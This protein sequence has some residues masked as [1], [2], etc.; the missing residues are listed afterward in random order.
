MACTCVRAGY[1]G[2]L[3]DVPT[4]TSDRLRELR[5]AVDASSRSVVCTFASWL[6]DVV[7]NFSECAG[8]GFVPAFC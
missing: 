8:A 5:L 3:S 4:A 1:T 6:P 7:R 2:L